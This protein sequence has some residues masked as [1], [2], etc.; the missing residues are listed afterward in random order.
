MPDFGV[1]PRKTAQLRD[2][3]E[4][5]GL[6]EADLEEH[7]VTGRGP[8]GQKVNRSA[9]CVHLKH[10]PSGIEVK[11]HRARSQ[12]LNRF[13]ARRRLCELL[14]A[15]ALGHDS[16]EAKRRAEIRKQKAR[17]R[18]RSRQAPT[19]AAPPRPEPP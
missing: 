6:L 12:A 11:T 15:A 4:R 16:P 13:Y 14:E 3:M 10:R 5:C 19:D 18:R 9:S 17:R 1:T 8:G 7:F 2:R